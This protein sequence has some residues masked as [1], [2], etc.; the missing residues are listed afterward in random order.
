MALCL[1]L[2]KDDALLNYLLAAFKIRREMP[3]AFGYDTFGP[4][5]YPIPMEFREVLHSQNISYEDLSLVHIRVDNYSSNSQKDVRVLYSGDF[6]YKPTLTFHRRDV[7]VR[8]NH[9]ENEKEIVIKEIPPNESISIEIFNPSASFQVIQVI[10]GDAEI[11]S[12][13]QKLAEA[14]R[15][16]GLARL[17]L[18]TIFLVLIGVFLLGMTGYSTWN[19]IEEN[20]RIE[21]A[22]SGFVSC[23]PSL[24]ENPPD[25]EEKLQRNFHRLDFKWQNTILSFNHVFSYDELKLKDEILWCAPNDS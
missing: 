14:R 18:A 10:S 22:Y 20:K 16:P 19:K 17:K 5:V 1:F 11:T 21:A 9:V 24:I 3:D 8:F 6:E 23:R 15:Y 25:Q 7:A 12:L 13:M 4:I 2:T